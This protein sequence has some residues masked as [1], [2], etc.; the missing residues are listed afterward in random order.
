MENKDPFKEYMKAAEP[1]PE[2]NLWISL[3]GFRIFRRNY[4][5]N[6]YKEGGLIVL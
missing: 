2:K 3:P 5:R 4:D 1:E 6:P